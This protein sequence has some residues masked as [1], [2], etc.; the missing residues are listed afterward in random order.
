[1]TLK[2]DQDPLADWVSK[3]LDD[4]NEQLTEQQLKDIQQVRLNAL[5][6]QTEIRQ[7]GWLFRAHEYI[8]QQLGSSS[9]LV[10][11]PVAVAVIMGLL[12]SYSN[13]SEIPA[14]PL[15]Y[16]STDVP[17]EELALLEDLDFATWLAENNQE[18][19]L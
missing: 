12:V 14:L 11:A 19:V 15:E 8:A 6:G 1:M 3:Q 2:S 4:A 5:R 9:V 7:R 13:E 10:A 16:V 18:S 17:S